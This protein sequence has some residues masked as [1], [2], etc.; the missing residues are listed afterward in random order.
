MAYRALFR[1]ARRLQYVSEGAFRLSGYRSVELLCD[2]GVSFDGLIHE[3]DRAGVQTQLAEAARNARP[4]RMEYRILTRDGE[5]RWVM[6]QGACRIEQGVPVLEALVQD[7]TERVVA[8]ND[9]LEAEL[10]YRSLFD[11]ASEGLFQTT[12]EGCYLAANPALAKIYGYDTPQQLMVDL[13]NI[14]RQLYVDAGRREEF[15]REI[16]HSGVVREFVSR[17]RQRDGSVIWISENAYKVR[18][19][20]G[21][22]LYYEGTVRDV[23]ASKQAEAR[24]KFQA[25]HDQLTGLP[26]RVVLEQRFIQAAAK[27]DRTGRRQC[28]AFLDLDNFKII[29]DSLGHGI[30]DQLLLEISQRLSHSLRVGDSVVRY[31][32]DEFVLLLESDASNEAI[33]QL[34][35]RIRGVVSRPMLLDGREIAA[36]C[37]IGVAFYPQ[38]GT[39]LETLLKHADAAM[40]SAKAA[41]RDGV[42]TFTPLLKRRATERLSIEAAL[43]RALERNELSVVYQP[44]IAADGRL[45]GLEALLRWTSADLGP[46][47]PD[48]FIPVAEDTGMIAGLTDFVLETVCTQ[49]AQWQQEGLDCPR[50]AINCSS[51]LFREDDLESA[52]LAVTLRTGVR[53]DMLDLEITESQLM[54]KPDKVIPILNRL[55]S[56][57]IKLA[58]DDFGTG[59]SSLAYLK[60]FPVDILKIDKTFVDTLS[61]ESGDLAFAKAIIVLGHSL[62]MEVVA[63]GVETEMQHELLSGLG[64]NEFQGYLFS[65]PQPAAAIT[66]TLRRVGDAAAWPR[67]Q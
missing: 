7:I 54:D 59:Y 56:H 19:S 63:E 46:I 65:R 10:R 38:D 4:Y 32:G 20:D 16:E 53:P 61:P 29:N 8:E 62:G 48:K 34:L 24:L 31:G 44:R 14:D 25:E 26:N 28:I 42:R 39:D 1:G 43:R 40:Y 9:L 51:R 60:R 57:G 35:E 66:D 64:C 12:A 23:T 58:V 47:P 21:H 55:R 2:G 3:G 33:G 37:S 50:V 41:G 6:D 30:G 49:V 13:R 22:F 45:A 67:P 15:M 18:A 27:A 36:S 17:V 5:T 52:I 11:N